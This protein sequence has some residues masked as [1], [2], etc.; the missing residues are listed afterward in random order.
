MPTR[1]PENV[2]VANSKGCQL[3]AQG[4]GLEAQGS[5]LKASSAIGLVSSKRSAVSGHLVEVVQTDD[6]IG[7]ND[8]MTLSDPKTLRPSD[9]MT[10]RP[11]WT[12]RRDGG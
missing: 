7:R 11:S 3:E 12:L 8:A 9:A 6:R 5:K 4:S 10:Q 2:R 1:V